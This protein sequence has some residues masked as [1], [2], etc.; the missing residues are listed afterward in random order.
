MHADEAQ[1][2]LPPENRLAMPTQSLST[3]TAADRAA[4]RARAASGSPWLA[5][6]FVFGGALA[7]TIYGAREMYFVVSV[8][9][10][11]PLQYVLLALFVVNFSWIALAFTS[12]VLGFARSIVPR[13]AVPREDGPLATR[14]AIV[15]PV[16]NELTARTF[17]AVEAIRDSVE[18]TGHGEA[19][20]Y[21]ILSDSTNPDAWL[22]EERAFHALRERIGPHARLYYRHREKNHHR[23]AGNIADFVTRWGGAYEQMLVL[24]ADS[25]MTG[26]CILGLMRA[27][28]ADPKAGIIQTLPMLVNRNTLLARLQQFAGRMAGPVIATGLDAWSGRSGNYWG[29]NAIIRTRAFA[30]HCGLPDLKGKP[31]F[32]GHVLSHDFVEAALIRRGGWSVYMLPHLAGSYEES[33]PSLIDLAVRDR[34]WCQGN[35]QH[36]RIIGARGLKLATRQHFATGIMA[37]L[38]SPFW[39]MQ[40]VVGIALVLQTTYIRPEYFSGDFDLFPAWPRFDPERALWLFALTMGILLAPKLF[41]LLLMIFDGKTRRASG[42]AIRLV[43]SFLIEIL[44]SALLAPIQMLVQSGSVF[45]ILIGRDT[46][47]NPQRRD[48]GSIPLG[49][50]V[51]RHRWHTALGVVAGVSAFMIATSLFLWMSPTILGLV[52]AIPLSWLSGSLAAGLALKRLGLLVTPEES[53]PPPIVTEANV[54]QTR[55]AE[56]GFD[57]QDAL[58][59][60]HGDPELRACHEAMLPHRSHRHRGEF[61]PD[62]VMAEAKII[63]AVTIE[64]AVAWLKPKERM[65][66][67]NDRALLSLAMRLPAEVAAAA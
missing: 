25:L 60:L 26:E 18:A 32:G 28:E 22:A 19:F 10:T 51:R 65:V 56:R 64:E 16:Y 36:S 55:N 63:D 37:Y 34:R 17:A 67:L 13:R 35:L 61:D 30:D 43:F 57:D 31:P 62:R 6:L 24:D 58:L 3:W 42:G 50:I 41:G 21:F 9:R 2:P 53:S 45:Q 11:T 8:S 39:L 52:L 40:L 14:T 33:P 23:K 46:G 5:R 47:W 27:M 12:G 7:L 54:L 38:A 48:D 15:M 29:H 1:P 59:V 20:D 66:V 44:L 49:D 4:A